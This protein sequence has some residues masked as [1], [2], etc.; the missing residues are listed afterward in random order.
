MLL[1]HDW[2]IRDKLTANETIKTIFHPTL[3]LYLCQKGLKDIK[4]LRIEVVFNEK[5]ETSFEG[6][7]IK[8]YEDTGNS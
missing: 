7:T 3:A 8:F 5:S 4:N 6:S 2:F 1:L